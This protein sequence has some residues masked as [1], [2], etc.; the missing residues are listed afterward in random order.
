MKKNYMT[1]LSA[2]QRRRAGEHKSENDSKRDWDGFQE[3]CTVVLWVNNYAGV[4]FI[5]CFNFIEI[6]YFLLLKK[7]TK[8]LYFLIILLNPSFLMLNILS[9]K[10]L[11]SLCRSN[12]ISVSMY[13]LLALQSPYSG[14]LACSVLGF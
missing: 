1:L 2:K 5:W 13:T 10:E 3:A 14:D 4:N 8:F 11:F 9:I 6:Y 7:E 12:G